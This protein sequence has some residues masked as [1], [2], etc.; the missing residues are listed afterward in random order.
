MNTPVRAVA[1]VSTMSL[2]AELGNSLTIQ[3]QTFAEVI[4]FAEHMSRS[5]FVPAHLRGKPADC[6]AVCLQ[7]LRWG[8]DPFSVGQKTY[9]T[10]EGSPP[11]Y[12]A[13][14][15][16]AV[17]QARAP[18]QRDLDVD[19]GGAWPNRTCTVT[20]LLRG[21]P[22]PKVRT[23]EAIKITVRNS[24]L[25]KTD[26]DQQLAYYTIRAWARLFAPATIMGVYGRDEAAAEAVGA[27]NAVDVT[28]A[29]PARAASNLDAL[30]EIIGPNK[31]PEQTA[32]TVT[33]DGEIIE[34]E[35]PLADDSEPYDANAEFDRLWEAAQAERTSGDLAAYWTIQTEPGAPAAILKDRDLA[36][37]KDLHGRVAQRIKTMKNGGAHA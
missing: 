28:P 1:P 29:Q 31:S 3:P 18:L 10:R 32:E 27:D 20:G 34:A 13:Q 5:T 25:W 33:A 26:P 22:K 24:P 17:V 14:L 7:A 4:S 2:Q 12:E 19:W 35:L 8:M 9:F 21:N 6:L 36:A 16:A 15:I 11:G 23:V 37:Y 30:E